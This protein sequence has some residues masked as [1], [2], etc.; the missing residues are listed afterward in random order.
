MSKPTNH[1]ELDH[2]SKRGRLAMQ[3]G[4]LL[5]VLTLI[6]AIYLHT[7][8]RDAT[9]AATVSSAPKAPTPDPQ[10]TPSY[11]PS[12]FEFKGEPAEPIQAY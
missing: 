9:P 4:A 8:A 11:L 3:A 1:P 2:Y 12:Q 7:P 6:G 5:C 10:P